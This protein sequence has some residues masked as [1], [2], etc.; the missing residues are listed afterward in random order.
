M[1]SRVAIAVFTLLSLSACVAPGSFRSE[2]VTRFQAVHLMDLENQKAVYF[3]NKCIDRSISDKEEECS[4]GKD[5]GGQFLTVQ[6]QNW[7]IDRKF[8]PSK[9]DFSLP[10]YDRYFTRYEIFAPPA[11]RDI[12]SSEVLIG[13]FVH[14]DPRG[15]HKKATTMRVWLQTTPAIKFFIFPDPWATLPPDDAPGILKLWPIDPTLTCREIDIRYYIDAMLVPMPI[16]D[17]Y[18]LGNTHEESCA[19][20]Q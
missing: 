11:P 8:L 9:E 15:A 3:L 1:K 19:P 12:G 14:I 13:D 16:G 5:E 4:L 6:M 7:R 18:K 20:S 10:N 17:E 2:T